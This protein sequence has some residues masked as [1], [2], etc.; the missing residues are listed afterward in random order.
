[1]YKRQVLLGGL[2]ISNTTDA[3]DLTN[4]GSLTIAGGASIA[5]KLFV[6]GQ[7]NITNTDNGSF[8]TGSLISAGGASF[9]KN[10]YVGGDLEIKT[11]TGS[12]NYLFT[13][14]GAIPEL[15]LQGMSSNT[16]SILNITTFDQDGTDNCLLY[17]SDAA[18]EQCMV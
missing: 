16:D 3:T 1:M 4:G 5:K 15:N 11:N 8:N 18:D 10:V 17:T 12:Q 13:D 7:V 14:R 2:G 9:T 6:G